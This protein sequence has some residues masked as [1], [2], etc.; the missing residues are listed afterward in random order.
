MD[1]CM[2]C[3]VPFPANELDRDILLGMVVVADDT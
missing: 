1:C 3:S 2:D